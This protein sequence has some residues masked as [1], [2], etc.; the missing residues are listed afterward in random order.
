MA[1]NN[2]NSTAVNANATTN[3]NNNHNSSNDSPSGAGAATTNN[4]NLVVRID[5]NSDDKL[6]ALFDMVLKPS[7]S[8]HP[9]TVPYR[10]RKLPD[11]FFN[12]PSTGSKSPSVS[13]SRENSTDSAFGSGTTTICSPNGNVT[14]T[15]ISSVPKALQVCH[16]RHHSSPAQLQQTNTGLNNNGLPT[17]TNTNNVL[18]QQMAQ[19]RGNQPQI[20]TETQQQ[21][22]QPPHA[23][24]RSYDIVNNSQLRDQL[25]E[26]PPGWE[27]TRTPDGQIY[28]LE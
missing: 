22:Q 27:M 1:L 4:E 20:A 21:Q 15:A 28:F 10:M 16:S 13:H 25:G 8:K 9:L 19:N 23:R 18:Q 14:P 6:Q 26:L 3:N 2:S 5:E 7:Q 12:P 17:G 11:S 24:Q